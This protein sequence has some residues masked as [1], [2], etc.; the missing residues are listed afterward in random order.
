M[1]K[2]RQ[3]G[4]KRYLCGVN[5]MIV[6]MSAI[7]KDVLKRIREVAHQSVPQGGRAVLYGS[8]A[9]GDAHPRSDWDVLILLD[10]DRLSPSDYDNVSFPFVSLGWDI[11]KEINPIMYTIDEWKHYHFT[12]FYEN[13][14]HDGILL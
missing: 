13:V 11:N 7:E 9:R 1:K 8:R 6:V 2:F 5:R 12:P 10:K 4:N 14:E 3:K